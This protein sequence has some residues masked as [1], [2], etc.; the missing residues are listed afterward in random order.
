MK[1][2]QIVVNADGTLGL[3][4]DAFEDTIKN[5]MINSVMVPLGNFFQRPSFG[6]RVT[7]VIK[8][9]DNSLELIKSYVLESL[10]WLLDTGR[11][12]SHEV[13]VT[14]ADRHRIKIDLSTIQADGREITFA[15]F[16]EVG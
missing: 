6:S 9:T 11:A 14:Q 12:V 4:F 8:I 10:Q 15:V 1:D 13:E 2:I 7:A 5:N 3:S 16:K